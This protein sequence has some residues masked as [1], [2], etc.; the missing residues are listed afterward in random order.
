M[1]FPKFTSKNCTQERVILVSLCIYVIFTN[2]II[3]RQ[4]QSEAQAL[5]CVTKPQRN[6]KHS[7]SYH[8][9]KEHCKYEFMLR[10]DVFCVLFD[11][12]H[13]ILRCFV[14]FGQIFLDDF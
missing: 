8:N 3:T 6:R 12:N 4:C 7:N 1:F 13:H 2:K 5:P 11:C 10:L 14:L 9:Q